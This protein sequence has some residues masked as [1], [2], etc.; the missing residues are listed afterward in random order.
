M[1]ENDLQGC[2]D[3]HV[4]TTAS[5]G[6]FRPFEIVK[7]ASILGLSAIAITD[8]DTVF[9]CAEAMLAASSFG[10]E[11]IPGIEISTRFEGAV[12]ILGYYIDSANATLQETLNWIVQDRD[13]NYLGCRCTRIAEVQHLVSMHIYI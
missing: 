3:L 13:P 6:T 8:H 10:M 11:V 1:C 9:G 5:D 12:H 4:H 2:V 7:K